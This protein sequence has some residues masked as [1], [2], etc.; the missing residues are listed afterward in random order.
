VCWSIEQVALYRDIT[1][2]ASSKNSNGTLKYSIHCGDMHHIWSRI[3]QTKFDGQTMPGYLVL[4]P[5]VLRQSKNITES[6]KND[7]RNTKTQPKL[8]EPWNPS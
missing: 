1:A 8:A 4:L 3:K 5:S 6:S 7:K 2:N